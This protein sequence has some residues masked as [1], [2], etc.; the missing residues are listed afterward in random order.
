MNRLLY[1]LL[2]T[3]I[4]FAPVYAQSW[5]ILM[6]H[7]QCNTFAFTNDTILVGTNSGLFT[8]HASSGFLARDK[9]AF[10]SVPSRAITSIFIDTDSSRWI[11]TDG[12]G[13]IHQTA[14]GCKR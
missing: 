8:Y 12:S 3:L 10:D 13:L 11:C 5:T 1:W 2:I 9:L 4:A 7:N 14:A 6:G